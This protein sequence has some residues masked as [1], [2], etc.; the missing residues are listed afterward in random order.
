M[1]ELP[2]PPGATGA[3]WLGESLAFVRDPFEF[4]QILDELIR[5]LWRCRK[6]RCGPR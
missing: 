4:F 1:N 5:G 3:P 2:L 6:R